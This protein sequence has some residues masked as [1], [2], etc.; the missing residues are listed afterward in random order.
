MAQAI[1]IRPISELNGPAVRIE[2]FIEIEG[3][4]RLIWGLTRGLPL[5][6][7]GDTA[8]LTQLPVFWGLAM[9]DPAF[10]P[11]EAHQ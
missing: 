10:Q 11:Q 3:V 6:Q 8:Y 1:D 9:G 4:G 5:Y 7:A 2:Q